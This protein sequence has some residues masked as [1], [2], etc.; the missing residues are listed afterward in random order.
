MYLENYYF[1]DRKCKLPKGGTIYLL[2]G[3]YPQRVEFTYK[4]SPKSPSSP[5]TENSEK[6]NKEKKEALKRPASDHTSSNPKVKKPRISSVQG[7]KSH[8]I[9]NGSADKAVEEDEEDIKQLEEKLKILKKNAAEKKF[10]FSSDSEG[11]LADNEQKKMTSSGKG[12]RGGGET[13]GSSL[14][15]TLSDGS[16]LKKTSAGSCKSPA[17]KSSS[18]GSDSLNRSAK[19]SEGPPAT[20][21]KWQP[22]EKLY[23]C[24]RKGV[25]ARDKVR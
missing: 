13:S 14:S 20:E 21:T 1:T 5:K 4:E 17:T 23:V 8:E 25:R 9:E 16:S 12:K 7:S 24:T 10:A 18:A 11:L 22:F 15:K 19:E 3:M 6:K 2:V